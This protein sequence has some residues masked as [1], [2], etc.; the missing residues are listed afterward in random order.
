MARTYDYIPDPHFAAGPDGQTIDLWAKDRKF[1]E[2]KETLKERLKVAPPGP[3]SLQSFCV[4]M[5]QYQLPS[6]VGNGTCE[7]LEILE[8][9]AHQGTVGYQAT[10][11]SRMFVWAMAR[12][13]EGTL[14]KVT[15][16]FVRTALNVVENLGVCTEITWPYQDNLSTVSPSLLA[17]R[18]ALGHTTHGA[19]RIDTQGQDRLDD[20]LTALHAQHPIVFGTQVTAALDNIVGAGPLDVPG[21]TDTILGGHCMVIVGWDGTDF[22]VKNSWGTDW[23]AGGFFNMTPAYVTW[24]NTTDLWVPTL[25]PAGF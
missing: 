17:Q 20:V 24:D 8:N 22:L 4:A 9:I 1:S 5:N 19:Y 13:Q 21:S 6:C 23:G 7:S 11:L 16:C 25:G 18:E 14:D 10:V 12:T 2:L 3:V 15:G